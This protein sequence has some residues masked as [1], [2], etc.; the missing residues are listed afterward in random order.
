MELRHL[1]NF[2]VIAEERS[3]TRAGE[4]LWLAQPGLSAQ[5]RRLEQE[6]GVT[7]FERH[8]RGV[9]LTDAGELF[10]E[11]ARAALAA[12]ELARSTG[13]DLAAGVVGSLR[14]GLAM[15]AQCSLGHEML[16]RFAGER[17]RVEVTVIESLGGVLVRKICDGRLDAAVVPA[18]FVPPAMHR[19]ELT[20]EPLTL[21]VG[22]DHRLAGTG[23]VTVEEL[24][25]E[26]LVTSGHRDGAAFDSAIADMLAVVGVSC[27]ECRGGW[28]SSFLT[29]V[30]TGRA[31]AVTTP[32]SVNRAEV[33][34]RRLEPQQTMSFELVWLADTP[35]PPLAALLAVASKVG[36]L[37]RL[38]AQR[39]MLA[40]A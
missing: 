11:R 36:H 12:A 38:T 8:T 20:T 37:P 32:C 14:I 5:I 35:S 28:G 25:G 27:S 22:P 31:V 29:A 30:A 16:E 3:F 13:Q 18:P 9:E 40:A 39:R 34:C 1:H 2:V 19:L 33:R 26:E 7:L 10:L 4:R 6:L 17:P 23:P 15:G 21:A 24:D